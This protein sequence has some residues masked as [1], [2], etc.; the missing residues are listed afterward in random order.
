MQL[1]SAEKAYY[2]RQDHLP[3]IETPHT[4]SLARHH[5]LLDTALRIEKTLL[6]QRLRTRPQM[7]GFSRQFAL[8][9]PNRFSAS[10]KE[11]IAI[12]AN[13]LGDGAAKRLVN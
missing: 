5:R 13:W 6:Q 8:R 4:F 10:S 9:A 11:C 12:R 1:P 2:V 7:D 3:A